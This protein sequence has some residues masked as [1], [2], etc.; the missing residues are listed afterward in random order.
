VPSRTADIIS[1][2]Q[3]GTCPARPRIIKNGVRE[4]A[5]A[6]EVSE[7]ISGGGFCHSLC[8]E[9]EDVGGHM[10]VGVELKEGELAREPAPPFGLGA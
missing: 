10:A 4:Y 8:E 1:S 9:R 3:S 2:A 6:R 5:C 7:W